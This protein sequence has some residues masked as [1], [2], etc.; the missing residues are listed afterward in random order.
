MLERRVVAK[1]ALLVKRGIKQSCVNEACGS[2]YYDLGSVPPTCPHCGTLCD[3]P[4]VVR[5]D[6]ETLGKQRPY[7]SNRWREPAKPAAEIA[8]TDIDETEAADERA[9]KD[10]VLPSAAEELLIEIDDDDEVQAPVE[11]KSEMT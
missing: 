11:P 8:K 4:A 7:K 5:V 2:P 10:P 9:E 3:T 1:S 6:F